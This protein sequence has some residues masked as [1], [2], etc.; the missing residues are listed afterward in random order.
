LYLLN[1]NDTIA[2]LIQP[3]YLD[4]L[5]TVLKGRLRI[6]YI[7]SKP[8]PIWKGLAGMIDETLLFDWIYQNYSVPPPAIPPR[9]SAN[10]GTSSGSGSK[11][12]SMASTNT[13][14]NF[15]P[16]GSKTKNQSTNPM[17]DLEEIQDIPTQQPQQQYDPRS[18][19]NAPNDGMPSSPVQMQTTSPE[20]SP[21]SQNLP[22][23]FSPLYNNNPHH[24]NE[25]LLLNERYN[26]MKSLATDNT[27]QVKL[28]VCGSSKFNDSIRKSLEKLGF[29]IDE[30]ALFIV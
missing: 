16:P 27:N 15:N 30:K 4:Y 13:I 3:A 19:F 29:P 24:T 5:C 23:Y 6:T 22:Y 10:Y 8:P 17:Y 28:V 18:Q 25:M 9:L 1:A 26:Y 14:T 20:Y 21:N 11:T 12:H 2:D 7:L